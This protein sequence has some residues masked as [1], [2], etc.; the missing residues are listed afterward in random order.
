MDE[1]ENGMEA[2]QIL[3]V[4]DNATNLNVLRTTLESRD[5]EVMVA[6]NGEAALKIAT[7]TSPDLILL[8]VMM[9]GID[10]FETCRRLKKTDETQKIPVIFLTAR[11]EPEN[12]VEGFQS[13]GVDY[14]S[15]PFQIDEVLAKSETHIQLKKTLEEQIQLNDKLEVVQEQLIKSEA[16]YRTIVETTSDL[17]FKLDPDQNITYINSAFKYLGYESSDVL[18]Q[19]IKNFIEIDDEEEML[20]LIATDG[21]GPLA[22]TSL[23]IKFKSNIGKIIE[24][25]V[26]SVSF[27]LDAFGVWNVSDEMVF[28]NVPEK[29]F[30]GTMCIAR[31]I[32]KLK[33]VEDELLKSKAQLISVN[34]ELQK[35]N[36]LD[37][38]TKMFNRRWFDETI[39]QEWK[40]AVREKSPLGLIMFDIDF[41]KKLNDIHGYKAGDECLRKTAATA[42]DTFKRPG[43]L[44]A[45]YGEEEFAAILPSTDEDGAF[46]IGERLR[47]KIESLEVEFDENKD[48]YELTISLGIASMIPQSIE[49]HSELISLA[50]NALTRAKDKGRNQIVRSS[51]I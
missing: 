28:Q 7:K 8:D 19:P 9:P 16:Q 20:P 15:K 26:D 35:I 44:L 24:E 13:G 4:D 23:K 45:R 3:L 29:K 30:L 50:D 14:I 21:V 49:G 27:L 12:I 39:N 5:Y 10:G 36:R 2:L 41:F 33:Q 34:A 37:G 17:I 1:E 46:I 51:S 38:L 47:K 6:K 43:D 32:T 25:K 31:E 18:G 48:D 42:F 40:R 11:T 22:T